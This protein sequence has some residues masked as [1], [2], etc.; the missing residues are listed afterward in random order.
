VIGEAALRQQVGSPE[1]TSAQLAYLAEVSASCPH[2]SIRILPFAAG[3]HASSGARFSVLQFSQVP[4]FGLVHIDGP[5]DGVCIDTPDAVA[6][7]TTAFLHM[8]LFSLT[9]EESA[10]RL[11]KRSRVR[12]A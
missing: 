4:S 10:A 1:V 2:V 6:A 5:G 9:A 8:Q 12:E 7:C 3:E 11:G